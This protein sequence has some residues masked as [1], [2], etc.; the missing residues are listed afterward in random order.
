MQ[1]VPVEK[2]LSTFIDLFSISIYMDENEKRDRQKW[3]ILSL[4]AH[5]R[6]AEF[7][8]NTKNL[9]TRKKS[10]LTLARKTYEV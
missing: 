2:I 4:R 10:L 7:L 1:R 8:N 9:P 5:S 6:T 3:T